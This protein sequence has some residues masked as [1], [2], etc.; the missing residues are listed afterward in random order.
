ML[1][2]LLALLQSP[3]DAI[4]GRWEGTSICVKAEWNRACHDEIVRYD[5]VRDTAHAGHFV[6]HAYKQVGTTWEWMGDV[7]LHYDSTGHRWAGDWSNS[8][9]HI[10]WSF[11]PRGT[12]LAGQVVIY[13]DRRKGRDVVVHRVTPVAP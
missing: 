13:P 4:L 1:A 2:L 5:V 8:R 12:D 10:E 6:H 7:T 11:W 9:V 3:A